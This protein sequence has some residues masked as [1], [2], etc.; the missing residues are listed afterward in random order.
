MLALLALRHVPAERE[1]AREHRCDEQQAADRVAIDEHDAG[2]TETRR[3]RRADERDRECLRKLWRREPLL[4]DGDHR[5]DEHDAE[6]MRCSGRDQRHG[7]DA[8]ADLSRRRERTEHVDADAGAERELGEIERELD[9]AL[10]R[11]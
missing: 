10:P 6:Q 8:R 1:A 2:Q 11:G 7:P 5:G 4:G 9:R 3:R